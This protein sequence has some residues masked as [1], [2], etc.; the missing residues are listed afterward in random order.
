MLRIII[1]WKWGCAFSC[2][3][4]R[5]QVHK[6]VGFWLFDACELVLIGVFIIGMYATRLSAAMNFSR[7][8]KS[9]VLR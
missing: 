7:K 4:W 3:D 5:A 8:V 2:K 6:D 9:W 1:G